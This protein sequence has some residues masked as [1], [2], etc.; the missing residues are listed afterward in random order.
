MESLGSL[1]CALGVNGGYSFEWLLILYIIGAYLRLYPPLKISGWWLLFIAVVVAMAAAWIPLVIQGVFSIRL[2]Q[3]FTLIGYTSPFTIVIAVCVFLCC[4]KVKIASV[5]L[6]RLILVVSSATLGV[7]LIH[8]Q[9]YF[10]YKIYT[11][12]LCEL[13]V[14][15]A[16]IYLFKLIV[17]T[18][19]TFIICVILDRIRLVMFN[20]VEL[21]ACSA[22][23]KLKNWYKAM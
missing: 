20:A 23:A 14:S 10:F 11:R 18:L 19:L 16:G 4:T 2:P 6:S 22:M 9:Q 1:S 12:K 8:T 21:I 13:S 17:V 7:Y 3:S 5:R 15:D